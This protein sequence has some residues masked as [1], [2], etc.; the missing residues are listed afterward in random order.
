MFDYIR[1]KIV[2]WIEIP[3]IKKTPEEDAVSTTDLVRMRARRQGGVNSWIQQQAFLKTAADFQVLDIYGG[4][5]D[6]SI[7]MDAMGTKEAFN[8]NTGTLPAVL[9]SW[10][11]Q[12]GFIGYQA[13]A[14]IAQQWL[15]NKACTVP[16]KDA[17][18]NGYDVTINDGEDT[19]PKLIAKIKKLD[20][21][22]Q[23]RKQMI[24]FARMNRVFGIRI[25][26]FNVESDDEDFYRKPFNIDGV[27]PG[28]YKGMTQVDPY[29]I[30]PELDADAVG[31]PASPDFYEPTW[32]RVAGK[33]YHRSHLVIIRNAELADVLKPS[34]IYGGIPLPQ[35]IYERIYAAERTA[36]EAPQLALTKRTNI[37]RT[38]TAAALGDQVKFEERLMAFNS[39]RDNFGVLAIDKE[40]EFDQTDTSLNDLDMLI[41]TQYQLVAA[42]AEMPATKL[43]G[44]TPKGFQSTG[45][46]EENTYYDLLEGIQVNDT[47][48]LDRHYELLV[49][50]EKGISDETEIEVVW[51]PC[52][53]ATPEQLAEINNKNSQ[54]DLNL[55]QTGAIDG[56]DVRARLAADPESGYSGLEVEANES[57]TRHS[58]SD[59]D[60]NGDPIDDTDNTNIEDVSLNG[61]Q[62]SSM[63]E[64]AEQIHTGVLTR[65]SGLEILTVA[66]PISV[67]QANKIIGKERPINPE[68]ETAKTVKAKVKVDQE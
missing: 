23:V 55:Q 67:A 28:S 30:T 17:I 61:A 40:E 50:S 38:D 41:M 2:K 68:A 11:V 16:A 63:V 20:K 3:K 5:V 64:V 22:F 31:N 54:T 25:V 45:E 14:S 6:S 46:A 43:L 9:F 60:D 8:L 29:W 26:I 10:Y 35:M 13:C 53:S 36:N 44:T 39:F 52:K 7:A 21:K 15:V 32:W 12:Q 37:I 66:F 62:V 1:N 59:L 34:Y 18:K 56:Y 48:L 65:E 57:D 33:R 58:E 27:K 49:R 4:T 51:N 24:E 42:I 47:M 19:D